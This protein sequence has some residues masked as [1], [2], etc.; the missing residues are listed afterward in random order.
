MRGSP[1]GTSH[2]CGMRLRPLA[3]GEIATQA[4]QLD[5]FVY[6]LHLHLLC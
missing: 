4:S 6:N 5:L 1:R 3:Q 2:C